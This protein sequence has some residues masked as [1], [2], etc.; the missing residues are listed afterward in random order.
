[1]IGLVAVLVVVV[2][3]AVGA[4]GQNLT[5]KASQIM[6]KITSDVESKEIPVELYPPGLFDWLEAKEEQESLDLMSVNISSGGGMIQ[7]LLQTPSPEYE[8]VITDLGTLGGD[9]SFA[10]GINEDGKVV[11]LSNIPNNNHITRAFLYNNGVMQDLG[12]L[13]G[14]SSF[15]W[16]GSI[17]DAGVVV[18]SSYVVG[19]ALNTAFRY[20]NGT[21]VSIGTLGLN[22]ANSTSLANSINSSGV[23]VGV[24]DN[25]G[26]RYENGFMTDIGT[27]FGVSTT[28]VNATGINNAGDII[29]SAET[30]GNNRAFLLRDGVMYH[31]GTLGGNSST[32]HSINSSG[33]IVGQAHTSSGVYHAF[34]YD[35]SMQDLGVLSNAISSTAYGIN[36][37]TN[38]VGTSDN[39][40][41]LVSNGTMK[42][43]STKV[44]NGSNWTLRVAYDI[45]NKGQIVGWGLNPQ[46]QERAFRLDPLPVGFKESV[47]EEQPQLVYGN[48][49]AKGS[50]K[51]SLVVV[52]HGWLPYPLPK[53]V[54]FVDSMSNA[55]QTYLTAHSLNNWQVFGYKWEDNAWKFSA[56]NALSKAIGEG[57][58]LGEALSAQ[59]WSNIHL[60]GH[61]A[62]AELIHIASKWI[63]VI[64]PNTVVHC[65]F[66]DP[67][68]GND[69]AGVT[70]YGSASDWSDSYFS[71]DVTGDV[72]EQPLNEAYNVNV[73][74]LGPKR[75][76]SKFRSQVT[77]QMEVCTKTI[78][79]HGWSIDFYSN[80]ITG[81]VSSDYDGFGFP[82]SKEGGTW[83]YATNHYVSGSLTNLG[84]PDP[85]CVND[86]Q[87]DPP[88]WIDHV[89][90]FTIL[91]TIPSSTGSNQKWPGALML[92]PGSPAWLAT[93]VSNT[94]P[95]NSVSFDA[96]FSGVT[97]SEDMLTVYWDTEVIGTIDERV[98]EP[99]LQHYSFKFQNATAN[100]SYVLSFRV[101]PFTSAKSSAILTN[102]VLHQVGISQPF[103]L[104]STTNTVGDLRVLELTGEAG[105]AY[106]I[107]ASTNLIDWTD[108]VELINTNGAV[109]F[110]DQDA[111]NH[112]TRFY[113][114]IAPQ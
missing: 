34:F 64:S 91:P 27:F 74:Q 77:G 1:M 40:A 111:T 45:N 107:Q 72:T 44:I 15:C 6:D 5:P 29:G 87:I 11:G 81:N 50:G 23:I 98:V 10:Y 42:D 62:G 33:A 35:T 30:N 49:P 100:S 59:G 112:P 57:V 54:G 65:T 79:Y 75:G 103:S 48:Y 61:S 92:T 83:D 60:I 32:A 80:T 108:I 101:D 2:W 43:L 114:G 12:T 18:G 76:M 67:Y 106:G 38:V 56:P 66:L 25:H 97:G 22:G 99:G 104:A 88:A 110:Y 8:Y 63:K 68:V 20:E 4:S 55:V 21:M 36:D 93:V 37:M 3:F 58:N 9:S 94:N 89:P 90:D 7:N 28:N 24:S 96:R 113:R 16:E 78:H 13:G 31:L 51:N 71:Y 86:I 73:T 39:R 105:F 85:S 53:D 26:F 46:G 52:T 95:V 69:N 102:I 82:L 47:E 70:D 109:R 84:T 14:S 41:F 17:N 19:N